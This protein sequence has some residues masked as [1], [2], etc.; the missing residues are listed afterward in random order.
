MKNYSK[1]EYQ[2]DNANRMIA[3][4]NPAYLQ[5]SY[6]YAVQGSTNAASA[7]RAGA[8][9]GAGRLLDRILSNGAKTHYGWDV[10]GRLTQLSN[11]TVTGQLINNTSYSRDRIGNI[12][13]QT[14]S[15]GLSIVMGFGG[16][17]GGV[18]KIM[19]SG[20]ANMH[21]VRQPGGQP[22]RMC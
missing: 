21:L 20:L 19:G 16:K 8:A 10:A 4:T 9:D 6:H 5:V 11:T 1:A 2:T 17:C 12:L 14:D 3:E 7:G 13:S 22:D 18:D 15:S